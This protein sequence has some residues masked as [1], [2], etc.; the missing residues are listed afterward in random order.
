MK[1]NKWLS[2]LCLL[3][4]A[5]TV[6]GAC[7]GGTSGS[8]SSSSE[9]STDVATQVEAKFANF[10]QT[11]DKDGWNGMQTPIKALNDEYGT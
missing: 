5:S 3:L 8:S 10:I 1:K 2:L 4:G 7:D 6:L 11:E 9:T